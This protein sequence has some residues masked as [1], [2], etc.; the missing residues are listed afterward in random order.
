VFR[1]NSVE[2]K[3]KTELRRAEAGAVRELRNALKR[4]VATVTAQDARG[5]FKRCGYAITWTR[6]SKT[7]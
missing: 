1:I 6:K 3:V 4:A 7:L 5:W 2:S